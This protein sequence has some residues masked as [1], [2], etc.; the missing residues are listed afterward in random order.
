MGSSARHGSL[1]QTRFFAS[2]EVLRGHHPSAVHDKVP[3]L[4]YLDEAGILGKVLN[5]ANLEM[6]VKVINNHAVRLAKNLIYFSIDEGSKNLIQRRS[7]EKI[8]VRKSPT[9]SFEPFPVA[10]IDDAEQLS[11][12]LIELRNQQYDGVSSEHHT[13]PGDPLSRL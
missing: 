6:L 8:I 9:T 7:G 10:A 4:R 11:H 13:C 12:E 2:A 3:P 5:Y 1:R